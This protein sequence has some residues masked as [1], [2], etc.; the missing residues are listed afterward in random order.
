MMKYFLSLIIAAFLLGGELPQAQAETAIT[1][2]FFYDALEP[3]GEW[4]EVGDYGY[5]WHPREV[6]QEWRPYTQGTWAYT[7]AGWT[8]ISDEPHG[9]ATYHYGRWVDVES[10][11]WVWVPDTEWGPAWVSWRRSETHIGWAPLP[12][13][14][15]FRRTVG[16]SSWVDSY[17]DI[18]PAS[19]SFVE[20]RNLGAPRLATVILEPRQN[21]TIINE[22]RNITKITYVNNVIVNEGPEYEV[23]SRVSAQPIRRLRL[24]RRADFGGDIRAVRSEQF[25]PTVVGDSLRVM[26][27]MVQPGSGAPKRIARKLANV[28]INRGWKNAGPPEQV[29]K[30]R[31][32]VKAEAK[33]PAELPPEPKFETA[34]QR[35][36][37]EP[38][39]IAG[40]APKA[41]AE[42]DAAATP[43]DPAA[44]PATASKPPMKGREKTP[45]VAGRAG[46]VQPGADATSADP[47]TADPTKPPTDPAKPATDPAK[48]ADRPGQAG[49]A[50][51]GKGATS[52]QPARGKNAPAPATATPTE[53]ASEPATAE[54]A[55]V[56]GGTRGK[57][58][59]KPGAAKRGTRTGADAP[60]EPSSVPPAATPRAGEAPGQ[61]GKGRSKVDQ[62]KPRPQRGAV[63]E[64]AAPP[65]AS[66]DRPKAGRA[67]PAR[68][69]AAARGAERGGRRPAPKDP[70][71][72]A[73]PSGAENAAPKSGNPEPAPERL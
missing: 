44:P 42:T 23:V 18:G 3:H 24:D 46:V 37:K 12:P 35:A 17:Y 10:A 33:P 59:Q 58:N 2:D 5:C 60:S 50:R 43:A 26:A 20:L 49:K 61:P 70:A 56:P 14:A 6:T 38:K 1:V 21:I 15:S 40:G 32:K 19:Y 9:W 53:P 69:G 13:E 22:T 64:P 27:P 67:D 62:P 39:A 47:A 36:A 65:D 31:M 48:D 55:N 57:A 8:W 30:L 72:A 41:T 45:G 73:P 54:P 71:E 29:E 66:A 34:Q 28:Q 52:T 63:D 51:T 68:P 11:G 16:L 4:I 25:R 7:D